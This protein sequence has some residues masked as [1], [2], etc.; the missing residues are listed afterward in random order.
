MRPLGTLA[1]A[2]VFVVAPAATASAADLLSVVTSSQQ[3]LPVA[4]AGF[5]WNGFYAG[6]YGVAQ[7]SPVGGAQYG[8]GLDVGVNARFEFVLVGAEVALHG[9][10]GGAGATSY[11]QGLARLGVAVTDDVVLYGAGGAGID[12]G[13]LGETDA[14]VG[15]GLEFAVSDDV[16]LRGQYLHGFAFTGGNPKEQVTFGANFHF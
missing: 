13:P 1:I 10:G 2:A 12:L 15:G 8:L 4:D 16:T 7:N 5:D 3:A 9:L 6:V 14:L 11:L